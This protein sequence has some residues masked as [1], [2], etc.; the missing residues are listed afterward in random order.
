[1]NEMHSRAQK[2]TTL[3]GEF[4]RHCWIA[5][6]K[7]EREYQHIF[8]IRDEFTRLTG[9]LPAT[10][11]HLQGNFRILTKEYFPGY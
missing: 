8:T 2:L 7:S 3:P 11:G 9:L 10:Q 1:M 6:E 4:R 5:A